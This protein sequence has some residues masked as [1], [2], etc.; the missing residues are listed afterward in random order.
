[1]ECPAGYTYS[2]DRDSS[3]TDIS[4]KDVATDN[5]STSKDAP[6][7]SFMDEYGERTIKFGDMESTVN[8]ALERC[9]HLRNLGETAMQGVIK[10]MV[11]AEVTDESKPEK[12]HSIE[13]EAEEK[14]KLFAEDSK[15]QKPVASQKDLSTSSVEAV[16]AP[17]QTENHESESGLAPI[18]AAM[19]AASRKRDTAEIPSVT[20]ETTSEEPQENIEDRVI[21]VSQKKHVDNAETVE[22]TPTEVTDSKEIDDFH[23]GRPESGYVAADER[24]TTTIVR[25]DTEQQVENPAG[26]I[27]EFT[28]S[29]DVEQIE[30][31]G[32]DSDR[33]DS[34]S[35]IDNSDAAETA[36]LNLRES[37][38]DSVVAT[39]EGY[40]QLSENVEIIFADLELEE[41][42][43]ESEDRA[44]STFRRLEEMIT[45]R[46]GDNTTGASENFVAIEAG[47]EKESVLNEGGTFEEFRE[48]SVG[49]DNESQETREGID[50]EH[51]PPEERLLEVV[52]I[53]DT[54]EVTEDSSGVLES[55][56]RL[57][58]MIFEQEEVDESAVSIKESLVI[59]KE[60]VEEM[61]TLMEELGYET[62]EE[63]VVDLASRRDLRFLL[64]AVNY[65][66]YAHLA[67]RSREFLYD[68]QTTQSVQ[69]QPREHILGKAVVALFSQ[70]ITDSKSNALAA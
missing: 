8:E 4:S 1:M 41:G 54:G 52:Q 24:G 43:F 23:T 44:V 63:A 39:E 53:I 6:P 20:V 3:E 7:R 35:E 33:Q 19:A 49:I 17:L 60:I 61:L 67:D 42:Q 51:M 47:E 28:P 22:A 68:R 18:A 45:E 27:G 40:K 36:D 65:M 30:Y 2:E 29:L 12:I 11:S 70:G 48:L 62:P 56:G 15:S 14:H 55:I 31:A 66:Y 25:S 32:D 37:G 69:G 10:A 9:P 13:S 59:T 21:G 64:D 57:H 58:E 16:K 38:V 5:D 50:I 34:S 26:T 46:P